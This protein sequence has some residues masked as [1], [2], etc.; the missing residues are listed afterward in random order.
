MNT[1]INDYLWTVDTEF[2]HDNLALTSFCL[3]AETRL[4]DLFLENLNDTVAY[5]SY[6]TSKFREYNIFTFP[7]AHLVKLY[8]SLIKH[9]SP[10]LESNQSYVVQAWVNIFPTGKSIPWHGH[11]ESASGV[12]HGYYCV[13]AENSSTLYRMDDDPC[14]YR[15]DNKN[16]LLV[17]G[18]SGRDEH[19]SSPNLNLNPRITLAF[20]IVPVVSLS[21]TVDINHYIPFKA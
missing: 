12:I 21:D 16:G 15:V 10:V 19:T 1:I 7:D 6:T 2:E 20:D 5:G 3:A 18:K 8:Y 9:I 14:V 11:W 13:S 17:F 4:K